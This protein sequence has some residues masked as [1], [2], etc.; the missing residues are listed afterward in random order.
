M[1]TIT[2]YSYKGGVGRSLALSKI[3]T[4]LSELGQRVCVIDFDLD[5]PGLR[6]KFR[7]YTFPGIEKGI[8]DY[9]YEFS[10]NGTVGRIV[11]YTVTAKAPNNY[12]EDIA[13][14][15]AGNI[16]S[17][18]YWKK[19]SKIRWYELFYSEDPQGIEFFLDMKAQIEQQ[20][21]PDFLL[22]DSRTGITDISGITLRILADQ[23]VVLGIKNEE[24]LF[25]CKKIIKSL[26]NAQ[27]NLFGKSPVVN[28]VLT[29]LAFF[30]SYTK[31]K[32]QEIETID[33]EKEHLVVEQIRNDFKADL[34][35]DSFDISVIH[36]DRNLE[37]EEN[38]IHGLSYENK[39][40]SVNRDY[41]QLF[42]KLTKDYLTLDEKSLNIK[43]AQIEYVK[44]LQESSIERKLSLINKAIELDKNKFEYYTQRALL[45]FKLTDYNGA[46]KDDLAALELAPG[47]PE[48]LFNIA[49]TN[50]RLK[51]YG[52]ALDYLEKAD[53]FGYRA[54]ALKGGMY[55]RMNR[56]S[57]ALAALNKAVELN[58]SDAQILNSRADLQRALGNYQAALSDISK[59]IQL[60]SNDPICF[61]T[62]AEIYSS[63]G[64]DE[65][66]F[67]NLGIAL[68]KDIPVSALN[69]AYDVYQKYLLDERFIALLNKYSIDVNDIA[70]GFFFEGFG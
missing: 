16:H 24:N 44:S 57:D 2:F 45:K 15:S 60:N 1:K 7:N 51:Q 5:A 64:R 66:F 63:M 3:A 40:G 28:F 58:P 21:K 14:I 17:D 50:L 67:L 61:A 27:N 48:I 9:I 35:L 26:L 42:D 25:G 38:R 23:V 69:S 8:V 36:T 22:I 65:E 30:K 49:V 68:S 13:F 4:M 34:N 55:K 37:E 19:L 31:E 20:F 33:Y 12:F 18:D 70:D 56:Y 59:A 54:I 62:L 41:L 52:E 46:L 6:F 29:R 32:S 47:A 10:E 11:D 53:D 43:K 39:P